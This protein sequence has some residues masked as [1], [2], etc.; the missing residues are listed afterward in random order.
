MD[1]GWLKTYENYYNSEV[2]IIFKSVFR[3]LL[4][5]AKY[6]YTVGDIAFFRKYYKNCIKPE[7]DEIKLLVKNGQLEIVH[8]G[9]VSTDEATTNYADILRNFEAA[10]DFLYEEF[11]IT[12]TIGMQLDPFGHSAVNARLMAEMGMEA[13]FMGRINEDDKRERMD[14][15]NMEWVWAPEFEFHEDYPAEEDK[16]E[17]F[18]HMHV[19]RYVPPDFVR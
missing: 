5:D 8:G 9:L 14:S 12:P 2:K 11:G 18:T 19:T 7:Q 16:T 1:A 3:K 4:T 10:H 6:T 15:Q 13:M 17:I